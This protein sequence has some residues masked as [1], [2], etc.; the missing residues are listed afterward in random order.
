MK[1]M[2]PT[3]ADFVLVDRVVLDAL[4]G[5]SEKNL[6]IMA[7]LMWMGFRQT[8]ITYTKQARVHGRSGWNLSKKLKLV[9]D[10][11]TAFSYF[12]IRLMSWL[13]LLVALVGF[14]YAGVV[15]LLA[16]I[17]RSEV[18]GWASLMIVVLVLGGMQML[19]MGVL[20]EYLWRALDESRSR[21]RILIEETTPL[22]PPR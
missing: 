18:Q 20:G 5:F 9:A 3:G 15:L 2:P 1:Q 4:A 13:G 17:G 12:P 19:M 21:P 14:A 7:L 11:V 22:H 8:T 16:L 6:S 10:S